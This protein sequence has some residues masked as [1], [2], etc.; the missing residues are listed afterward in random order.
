MRKPR[1]DSH[2]NKLSAP[3]LE[4]LDKWLFEEH[5]HYD[6][7]LERVKT[8]FGLKASPM[9][10]SRYYHRRQRERQMDGLVEAQAMSDVVAVP[11]LKTDSMR[12]AALKLIAKTT[13]QLACERPEQLKELESLAKVLLLSEDN[14]IRRARLKL[15]ESRLRLNNTKD[16]K[17]EIPMLAR[18]LV[19]IEEDDNLTDNAKLAKVHALLFPKS[20]AP[21]QF[22]VGQVNENEGV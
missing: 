10:L 2:W 17:G 6:V 5:L 7:A 14:D 13:L 1:S 18:L 3:Q 11:E 12:A 21:G 15:E 19:N 20:V 8:E 9:S 22:P 16:I 4:L